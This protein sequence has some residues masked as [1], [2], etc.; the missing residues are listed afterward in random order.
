MTTEDVAA[1]APLDLPTSPDA[2][3]SWMSTRVDG[4]LATAK[5]LREELKSGAAAT[6]IDVLTVWNDLHVALGNAFG[7][8][9][10]MQQV[11][12]DASIRTQAEDAEQDLQR[13]AT[14]LS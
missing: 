9:G 8:V 7:T 1:P 14:E 3:A 6:P 4:Q 12:P 5:R 13:F 2:W 11:H 10:L